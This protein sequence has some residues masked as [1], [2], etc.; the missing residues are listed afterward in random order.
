MAGFLAR[1]GSFNANRWRHSNS[2]LKKQNSKF[3]FAE[4]GEP[5]A[6]EWV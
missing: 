6:K 1:K 5:G 2:V 3:K 4:M